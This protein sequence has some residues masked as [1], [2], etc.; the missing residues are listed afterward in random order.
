MAMDTSIAA[1]VSVAPS[2]GQMRSRVLVEVRARG[3]ATCD[4][5]EGALKMQHQTA[6]ARIRE[7]VLDG[8]LADSGERRLTKSGR[9]AAV[10]V[11]R[12]PME[13]V[14]RTSSG[15]YLPRTLDDVAADGGYPIILADPPWSYKQGGRGSADNH[16]VTTGIEGICRLPVAQLA[17]RDAVLFL[18]VTWPFLRDCFEVVDRWGFNFKTCAFVWV[19]YHEGSGKRCVG[20]GFWTR[21]NTEFCLLCVRG[22]SYPRRIDKGVR[23]LIESEP[24]ELLL[25]PRQGHSAKPPEARQRIRQLLGHEHAAIELFARCADDEGR[26]V[27]GGRVDPSFDQWGN[28]CESDVYMGVDGEEVITLL[29]E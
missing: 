7:L 28:E 18:W 11:E 14:H 22:E 21:A 16:Y 9:R 5:V 8:R 2:A 3:G 20:G 29:S 4:E 6:S 27:P 19:K 1:A 23:Q 12:A 13:M 24:E 17:S 10:W 25:A 15:L 26:V